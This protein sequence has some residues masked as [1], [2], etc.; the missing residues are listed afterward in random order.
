MSRDSVASSSVAFEQFLKAMRPMFKSVLAA[1]RVPVEDAEDVLQQ[2]LLEFI[3]RCDKIRDPE[4]WLLVILRRKCFLY[5]RKQRRQLH[6][7]VDATLLECLSQP[8]APAQERSDLR[9]D[10]RQMIE[11]LPPRCRSLLELRFQLGY[12]PEEIAEQ[13]GYR[14]SSVGKI[15]HRCLEALAREMVA[16]VPPVAAAAALAGDPGTPSPLPSPPEPLR[17]AETP[18]PAPAAPAAGSPP[19]SLHQPAQRVAQPRQLEPA[20]QPEPASPVFAGAELSAGPPS[21]APGRRGGSLR[22]G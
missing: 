7:A 18:A 14:S 22:P 15:T 3:E 12:S 21:R 9:S 20:R 13:L 4:R 17:P 19:S 2:A 5:R 1:T 11:R 16:A 8:V 10:L 6:S